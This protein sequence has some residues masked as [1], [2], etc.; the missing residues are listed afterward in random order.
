M[1]WLDLRIGCCELEATLVPYNNQIKLFDY[2]Q[3][4]IL[5]IKG[6]E[7]AEFQNRVKTLIHNT[8]ENRNRGASGPVNS[9]QQFRYITVLNTEHTLIC[10][11]D[12]RCISVI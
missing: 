6:R 5:G 3:T 7:I 10:Y 4:F 12:L 9:N 8:T 1:K 2:L 11:S